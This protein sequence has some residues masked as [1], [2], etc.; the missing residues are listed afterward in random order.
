MYEDVFRDLKTISSG[1]YRKKDGASSDPEGYGWIFAGT[2]EIDAKVLFSY[3]ASLRSLRSSVK[4][5]FDCDTYADCNAINFD[6]VLWRK[7]IYDN[8]FISAIENK[9][10][11]T[12]VL[13]IVCDDDLQGL[14]NDLYHETIPDKILKKVILKI[15]VAKWNRHV[16]LFC[17]M[18]DHVYGLTE[19]EKSMMEKWGRRTIISTLNKI[20]FC[21]GTAAEKRTTAI[22]QWLLTP[23]PR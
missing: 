22:E 14:F 2:P 15:D 11:K 16:E 9:H 19:K 17:D 18:I 10:L 8:Y 20:C 12:Y 21:S 3:E 5:I 7:T 1:D 23:E 6:T 13:R 4:N